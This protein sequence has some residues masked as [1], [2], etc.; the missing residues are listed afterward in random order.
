[1]LL[2]AAAHAA[3]PPDAATQEALQDCDRNQLTMNL[4]A[5]HRHQE[6]DRA[7]NLQ[8]RQTLAKQP[9]DAARQRLRVAQR[10][11]IAFRDKDC[12]A[13]TGPREA[14]G[15]IWPLLQSSCLARHTERR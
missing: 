5:A 14:S 11:W 2:T 4:C 8:Y 15:S 6:A 7:L 1:L 10:A 9:D 13:S 12:L 3:P